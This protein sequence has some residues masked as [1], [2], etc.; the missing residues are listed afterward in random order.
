MKIKKRYI[1][2]SAI[3]IILL[4]YMLYKADIG[5]VAKV[6]SQAKLEFILASFVLC[7]TDLSC[8]IY[9]WKI[10]L[11]AYNLK[12]KPFDIA[13]SFLASLFLANVTP[14][15]VGE[16]SRPY[17]LK[18]RYNANFFKILPAVL[19]ERFLDMTVLFIFAIIFFA[20]FS[21]F[22]SSVLQVVLI[23]IAAILVFVLFLLCSKSLMH[24]FLG[25][26]FRLFGRI[27]FVK[28][29]QKKVTKMVDDFYAG[30]KAIKSNKL[31]KVIVLTFISWT[32]EA[33]ILWF[34]AASLGVNVPFVYCAG[35][36]AIG[37]LAGILSSLPGGLGSM[38]AVFFTFFSIL[39]NSEAVSFSIAIMFRFLSFGASV[40]PSALFFFREI[41]GK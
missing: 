39:G 12:V 11:S 33:G 8:K 15:R 27:G 36:L 10:F 37:V 3:S 34:S 21:S 18:K 6:V 19:V 7:F 17:F 9:R 20:F 30:V 35:V 24:K 13:S 28:K 14:A 23:G 41:K 40:L 32:L 5:A 26:F 31:Y 1:I 22:F 25:F 2:S 4:A 29:L 38:E 16:A